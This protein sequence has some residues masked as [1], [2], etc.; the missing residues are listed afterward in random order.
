MLGASRRGADRPPLGLSAADPVNLRGILT[1]EERVPVG[2][3]Q[4]VVVG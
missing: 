1:P 4:R 3:K 2:S